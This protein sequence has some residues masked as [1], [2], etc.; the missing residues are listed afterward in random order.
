MVELALGVALF[1]VIVAIGCG[2]KLTLG[3]SDKRKWLVWGLLLMFGIGPF[4]SFLVGI[5]FGVYVGDGFAGGA[6]MLMLASTFFV[7]GLMAM[8]IGILKKN[9]KVARLP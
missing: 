2:V 1:V 8:I 4:L 9:E 6:V 7:G 5:G 3:Q